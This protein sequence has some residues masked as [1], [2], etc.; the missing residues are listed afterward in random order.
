MPL[1][2][3]HAIKCGLGLILPC[4]IPLTLVE[5][6][7]F[8]AFH[9]WRI[10]SFSFPSY[11]VG[12]RWWTKWLHKAAPI[13]LKENCKVLS[14]KCGQ[15]PVYFQCHPCARFTWISEI[16]SRSYM[17]CSECSLTEGSLGKP[18]FV[19]VNIWFR[20]PFYP[21]PLRP[22]PFFAMQNYSKTRSLRID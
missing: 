5:G 8:A 16:F 19:Q 20:W 12:Q 14:T 18:G 9:I 7:F 6:V 2:C 15:N 1:V 10:L 4:R 22:L 21:P 11:S 17:L 3:A 13:F